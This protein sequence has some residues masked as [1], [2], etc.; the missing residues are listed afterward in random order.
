MNTSTHN[1]LSLAYTTFIA[2]G[3]AN[4]NVHFWQSC[5][6]ILLGVGIIIWRSYFEGKIPTAPVKIVPAEG[7]KFEGTT[8][9]STPDDK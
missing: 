8:T 4:I 3:V 5:V 7:T 1:Y 9:I 6:A 2:I